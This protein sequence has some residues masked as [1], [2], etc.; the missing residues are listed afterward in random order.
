LGPIQWKAPQG[1]PKKDEKGDIKYP[2][3]FTQ[4][5][6]TWHW[7]HTYTNF[8]HFI[9]EFS[10]GN[11]VL[12]H[13]E[14]AHPLDLRNGELAFLETKLDRIKVKTK[15]TEAILP[16]VVWTPS[17]PAPASPIT[18]NAGSSINT[19]VPYYWDKVSA[20]YNGFGCRL[21]KV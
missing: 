3:I 15:V 13:P 9:G 20:Q 11:F 18:G 19:I 16:G 12:I 14:T 2:L 10:E 21:V 5:K 7:Q 4:G 8:S 1:S 6:V 17:H